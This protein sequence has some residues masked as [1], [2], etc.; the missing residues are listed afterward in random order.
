MC[1]RIMPILLNWRMTDAAADSTQLGDWTWRYAE[2]TTLHNR[3]R[4]VEEDAVENN[5][6]SAQLGSAVV[7]STEPEIRRRR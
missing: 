5:A 6:D 4:D 1:W 7:Q 3:Y 2:P